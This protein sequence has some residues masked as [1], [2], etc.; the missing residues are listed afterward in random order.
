MSADCGGGSRLTAQTSDMSSTGTVK[1]FFADK[2]FGFVTPDDG[3]EDVFVHVKEN[4]DLG[5]DCQ[6]GEKVTYDAEWDDRKSKYKGSNVS[7]T[8]PA[9]QNQVL[10][11]IAAPA[12]SYGAPAVT[13]V[14]PPQVCQKERIAEVLS[15]VEKFI[16]YGDKSR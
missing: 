5:E 13:Y 15:M 4:P 10:Q 2:G 14:E 16:E 7:I 6:G 3:S 9:L 1:K 8:V 11:V 12:V